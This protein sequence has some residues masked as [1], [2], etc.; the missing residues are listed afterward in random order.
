MNNVVLNCHSCGA[1]VKLLAGGKVQ[2]RDTCTQ[3][4]A[5]LHCCR[6]CRFFDP[7]KNN[8]C[9]E[10]QADWVSNKDLANFCDYFEPRTSID[11]VRKSQSAPDAARKQ[12]D[13]L[14]KKP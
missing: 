4:H 10:P 1:P 12:F 8:Q 11:L 7:G 13:S 14:F 3:C 5:D 2:R 9:S 6:S